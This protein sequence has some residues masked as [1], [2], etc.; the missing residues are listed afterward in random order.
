MRKVDVSKIKLSQLRALVAVVTYGSF[1][2]ASV[3]LDIAQ[4]SVSHAIAVL[5][6][7]LGVSLLFRSREGASLTPVG[8]QVFEDIQA[9]LRHLDQVAVKAEQ[10]RGANSGQVRVG[11][12]RSLAT[13]WLPQA[14]ATFK[15]LY[16]DVSVTVTI[17]FDHAEVQQWLRDRK[18]DVGLIDIYDTTGFTVQPIGKDDYVAI[19]PLSAPVEDK[20]TW[21]QLAQYPLIMP[22]SEDEGY[23]DL[24][25]YVEQAEVSLNVAYE[26][27]ED[28]TIVRMV[29]QELG[30]A[31][32]PKLAAFPMPD[33]VKV[34]QLPV[35]LTRNLVA[36]ILSDALHSPAVFSFM[37]TIQHQSID[38]LG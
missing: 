16:P 17:C 31:I 23:A 7:S 26:I 6:E 11:C 5:E 25:A 3:E 27:N 24:R 33:S 32:L 1:S 13:Y 10:A 35:P 18:I 37:K 14:L 2:K 21:S 34:C 22:I 29:A 9:I 28:A 4:S 12:I 20:I 15:K 8:E 36:A 30:I 38:V 19:V